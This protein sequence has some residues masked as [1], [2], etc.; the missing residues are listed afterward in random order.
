[1][2]DYSE[3]KKTLAEGII[4]VVPILMLSLF[5]L[6]LT[7]SLVSASSVLYLMTSEHL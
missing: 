3:I 2:I 6:E 5:L 7:P 1:M 4:I